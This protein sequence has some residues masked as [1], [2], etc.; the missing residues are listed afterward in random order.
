MLVRGGYSLHEAIGLCVGVSDG[1]EG[2]ERLRQVQASIE[3]GAS[4]ALAF[5]AA[6][7]TDAVTERLLRAGDRGGDF[8]R[9]L[10]AIG[11]R[12]AHAFETFVE[13]ATRVVEP[14]LLLLVALVVGGMVLLLY[15][16]IFDIAA[17]VR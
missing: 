8:H 1:A 2:A 5:S 7:M 3:R 13:R 12:H 6:D 9:V 4:V 14:V 15:M 11:D 16:P 10:K 17:S